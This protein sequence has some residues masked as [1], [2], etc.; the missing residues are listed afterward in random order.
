MGFLGAETNADEGAGEVGGHR[1]RGR[2]YGVG[3]NG[4]YVNVKGREPN[5][6][7]EPGERQGLMKEIAGK[8][9]RVIDPETGK[10]AVGRAYLREEFFEDRA[11]IEIGPD[12]VIGFAKG[13][14][15]SGKSA[16]GGVPAEIFEDNTEE[17]TG[18]HGM[19]HD[20][21]PGILLTNR[22]LK[23]P[24]AR[25]QDLAGAILAEYGIEGFPRRGTNGSD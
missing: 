14:G 9:T 7:V 20:T 21:V 3:L 2:A 5:G 25:L 18:D 6:I 8:I 13:T 19:D 12:L 24:A 17:W 16:L 15:G 1:T 22:P 11:E 10:P 23:K 4:L